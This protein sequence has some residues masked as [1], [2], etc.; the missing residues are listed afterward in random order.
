MPFATKVTILIKWLKY[1][2]PCSSL[3]CT[4][5]TGLYKI[6]LQSRRLIRGMDQIEKALLEVW[7]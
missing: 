1:N 3:Q 5:S 2:Y 6:T 7:F 4:L